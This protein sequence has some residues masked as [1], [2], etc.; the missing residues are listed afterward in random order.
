MNA[1]RSAFS[2]E[3]AVDDWKLDPAHDLDL[4]GMERY[5]SHR[6]ESGLV[7]S[8]LRLVWWLMLR[9]TFRVWNRLR[10]FGRQHLPPQPPYVLIANHASHLDAVL[11]TTALP[12]ALR[13]QVFPIA[14][15]D[16]FFESWGRAA[17]TATVVNAM[18]V[19]R[20]ASGG[21]GLAS[22]RERLVTE[23]CVYIL[24]PEGTRTRDG[25][26]KAFKPGI[27]MLV[28][29]TPVPVVPCHIA[30]AF[31]AMPPHHWLPHPRPLAIR[32]G[33]PRCFADLSNDRPGWES[34]AT[35]LENDVRQLEQENT[36]QSQRT[37]SS[38]IP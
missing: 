32:L 29:G 7:A 11:L 6:R 26:M 21:H 5:R 17:F 23:P 8:G 13:D 4:A 22:L 14:A 12:L 1:A 38:R 25:D 31:T 18:P 3:A 36:A 33:P 10:I 20:R 2:R 37:G 27:G 34:C 9:G 35:Q 30:G 24:F 28:A 19:Q 15:R 16:V